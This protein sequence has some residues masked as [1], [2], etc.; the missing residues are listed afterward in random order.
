[1]RRFMEAGTVLVIVA[2]LAFAVSS[3]AGAA[4]AG[5]HFCP[6]FTSQGIKEYAATVGT[7]YTC[8]SA[9][10]WIV[11]LMSEGVKGAGEVTLT[12]GPKGLRCFATSE[13]KGHADG[14]WCYKGPQASPSS[15]FTWG[16]GG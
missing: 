8:S 10:T 14:G 6:A 13:A 15:G 11:K 4:R 9:K 5:E 7:G 2:G 1:M 16:I 12:N 3:P